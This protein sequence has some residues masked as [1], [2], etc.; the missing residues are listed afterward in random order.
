V[1]PW[2]SG[3]EAF[4]KESGETYAYLRERDTGQLHTVSR[5]GEPR[6]MQDAIL[7]RAL[8]DLPREK[9]QVQEDPLVRFYVVQEG[10]ALESIA[11]HEKVTAQELIKWNHLKDPSLL[12][13]GQKLRIVES[14]SAPAD[15]L[16]AAP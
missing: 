10:D 8:N 3:T 9:N 7:P 15:A 6:Q 16:P 5:D 11:R 14:K 13:V 12:S 2:A 1:S 4:N